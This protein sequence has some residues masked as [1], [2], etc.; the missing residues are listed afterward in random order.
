M[1]NDYIDPESEMEYA[2]GTKKKQLNVN[3]YDVVRQF[4]FSSH[5]KCLINS[6]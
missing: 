5:F 4:L 6:S 1:Q 3:G 2:G